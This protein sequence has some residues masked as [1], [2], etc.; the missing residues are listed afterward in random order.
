MYLPCAL[1]RPKPIAWPKVIGWQ[2][3]FRF[4]KRR[5]GWPTLKH[6]YKSSVFGQ[7]MD[8]NSSNMFLIKFNIWILFGDFIK[9]DFTFA[10]YQL[11]VSSH[12]AI[13]II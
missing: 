11:I 1:M 7:L 12:W 10:K 3:H 6:G 2:I 9:R 4:H 8:N 5:L 13:D